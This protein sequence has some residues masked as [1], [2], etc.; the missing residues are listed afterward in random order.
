MNEILLDWV[1]A[2]EVDDKYFAKSCFSKFILL[3]WDLKTKFKL[4]Y[5]DILCIGEHTS[6]SVKFPIVQINFKGN[7][8]KIKYNVFNFT[9]TVDETEQDIYGFYEFYHI[10]ATKME[11]TINK[12]EN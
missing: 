5:E 7:Q 4:E 8:Y 6:K 10:L 9:L 2:N 1:R 11:T 12:E 3:I